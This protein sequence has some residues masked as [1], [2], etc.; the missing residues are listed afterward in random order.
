MYDFGHILL[1]WILCVKNPNHILVGH[2]TSR[3]WG[4]NKMEGQF[5]SFLFHLYGIHD[6]WQSDMDI[7]LAL[8]WLKN[9]YNSFDMN[10]DNPTP[11]T[12]LHT[13]L[14]IYLLATYHLSTYLFT[15]PPMHIS[16][17]TPT[18][19]PTNPPTYLH[20]YI[21][22]Y[23]PTCPPTYLPI[24][25]PTY[26]HTQPC[27]YYL[28]TYLLFFLSLITICTTSYPLSYNLLPTS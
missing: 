5:S 15:Y 14:F 26:E 10:I 11:P 25:L 23:P 22:A 8:Q 27:T 9:D 19:L 4:D 24:Y 21:I 17:H 16:N 7:Q 2:V 1:L 18:Y 20:I 13:H 6:W 3:W 12:Y 28:F